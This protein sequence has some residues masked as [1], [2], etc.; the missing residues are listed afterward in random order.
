M[1]DAGAGYILVVDDD[2]DIR[3][4]LKQILEDEGYPALSAANGEE[5]LHIIHREPRPPRLVLLD[6]MMPVMDGARFQAKLAEDPGLAAV[7]VVVIS[8]GASPQRQAGVH[9]AGYLSKPVDLRTLM[10]TI[11][12]IVA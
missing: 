7:P 3:L 2:E 8:A 10:G 6:L 5:A 9:A 12:G 11:R 1:S 4:T